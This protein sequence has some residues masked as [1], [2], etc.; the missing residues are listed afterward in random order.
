MLNKTTLN[1]CIIGAVTAACLTACGG[2]GTSAEVKPD[3]PT[4]ST[5]AASNLAAM[6]GS[7][8]A[9]DSNTESFDVLASIG[10]TWRLVVDIDAINTS[11]GST[12]YTL[13]PNNS[14]YG[15]TDESGTLTRTVDGDF[16]TYT[17]DNKID[18]KQDTRTGA[19]TGSMT[20]VSQ[21]SGTKTATVSGT[22][23]QVADSSKLAGVYTFM[24]TT[25]DKVGGAN[26]EFYAGQMLISSSGTTATLCIGGQVDASGNCIDVD[27]TDTK[28]PEKG[29]I[30]I[31]KDTG[32]NGGFYKLQVTG[33]D[34]QVHDWG[35]LMVGNG[36]LGTVL[37]IDRF[38]NGDNG[39]SSTVRVGNFYAVKSQTL[40]GSEFQGTWK[41]GTSNGVAT[42]VAGTGQATITNPKE[43]P[44]TWS[45]DLSYNTVNASN[46]SKLSFAGFMTSQVSGDPSSSVL[47]LPLSA[48]MAVVENQ[49]V[50]GVGICS[51][52]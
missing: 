6:G 23:Y 46:N 39:T 41:C 19:L 40:K 45:E 18:L 10:D 21:T 33:S 4:V 5:A 7:V 43:A 20:V 37:L 12:T 30:T 28:T 13:T 3:T 44:S 29:L 48:S 26:A 11:N 49:S 31:A 9:A 15:L 24:G 50:N 8:I 35:N 51:K 25:R 14:Q 38:G 17:L 34:N 36:D 27:K 2:G 42:V 1:S 16:V 47:I 52:I 32:P 22:P